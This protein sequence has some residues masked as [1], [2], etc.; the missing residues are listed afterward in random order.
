MF[1][2]DISSPA[3]VPSDVKQQPLDDDVKRSTAEVG[4]T[5][6]DKSI[7]VGENEV[8]D[9]FQP[10][11]GV[12]A[13]DGRRILTMRAVATGG[14]LGSLIACSNLYLGLKTGM[15]ADASLFSAIFGYGILKLLEKSNIPLLSGYFGPHENNIVQATAIGCIGVGFIFVSGI[16]ALIQMNLLGSSSAADYG[17]LVAITFLAGFWGLAFTVPLRNLFILRMAR[18]LGLTF[19]AASASALTIRALHASTSDGAAAKRNLKSLGITFG[20][21]LFWTVATSYAPGILYSWN[22]FW[23]VYKWGGTGIIAAISWGWLSWSWSPSLLGLGAII[24]PNPAGSLLLGSVLAWGVIGPITVHL[25]AASGLPMSQKYEGLVTYNAF[26]PATFVTDPSP[27]YWIL[28]PA[29]FMML[30][31]SLTTMA[32]EAKSFGRLA[33][34]GVKRLRQVITSATRRGHAASTG[35]GL[36]ADSLIAGVGDDSVWDPIPCKY[37][38]RWWEWLSLGT[39]CFVAAMILLPLRFA[40]TADMTLLHLVLGFLWAIAV[41]QVY[42]AAGITP[43]ASVSKGSQFLTGS[44]LRGQVDSIGLEAA[45]RSNLMGATLSAGA[46]QAAAEL[47]QDFKT[48]FLLG[49]PTR[50]QYYAQLIGTVVSTLL[51]PGI[52]LLFAKAFPCIID[53]AATYCQFATPSVTAW[54]IITVGILAPVMPISKSSWIASILFVAFGVSVTVLKTLLARDPARA[55]WNVWVPSPSIMGLAMTLPGSNV[56]LTISIGAFVAVLWSRYGK[57]SYAQY[58]YPV[59]AGAVS[60]EGVGNVILSILQIAEVGGTQLGTKL[61]C[62]AELC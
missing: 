28:W 35:Q 52:F 43:I 60:G 14:L 1:S 2:R 6:D 42:G 53:P 19:P 18:P 31:S 32:M 61:G 8:D 21:S 11:S 26:N 34:Y 45:A 4:D 37:R 51:A 22:V 17:I 38:V 23:W 49:T 48:G 55:K 27:R 13:Y 62:V 3:G 33:K 25:G 41:V 40:V 46:A 12:E 16:P 54:R 15:A 5:V 57:K 36:T 39:A 7:R 10:L 20:V 58:F 47:C 9:L 50:Q 44:I 59:A 29:V 24:G 56:S 30:A